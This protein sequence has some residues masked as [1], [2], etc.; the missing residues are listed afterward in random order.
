MAPCVFFGQF[1][2]KKFRGHLK[3]CKIWNNLSNSF[4]MHNFLECVMHCIEQTSMSM[5]EFIDWLG[6]RQE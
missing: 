6:S 3:I 4:F 2:L 5:T 1:G